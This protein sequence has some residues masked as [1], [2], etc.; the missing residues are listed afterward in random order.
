MRVTAVL[1]DL[2]SNTNLSTEIFASGRSAY[3][4]LTDADAQPPTS[5]TSGT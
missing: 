2:P 3:S 1:K 4:D 5:A